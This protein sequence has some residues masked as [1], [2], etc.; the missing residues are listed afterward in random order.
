MKSAIDQFVEDYTLVIDNDQDAYNEA[1]FIARYSENIPQA[2][3][4]LR[5]E[6][7]NYISEVAD[8]EEARGSEAGALL[9]RQLLIGYGSDAFDR[10]AKHYTETVREG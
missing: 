8:R 7:E 5:E 10:I 6:F 3:D 1:C 4:K 9:I 2:S